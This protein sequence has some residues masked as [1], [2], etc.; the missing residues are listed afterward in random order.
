MSLETDLA[1]LI[2][3]RCPRV[4]ADVAPLDTATP[5]VTWQQVGG[6]AINFTDDLVPTTRNARVQI[7]VWDE[8]RLAANALML[9]LEA[10]LIVSAAFQARAE[11]AGMAANDGDTDLRGFMQ[12]FSIWAPR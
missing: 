9:Q 2:A 8:S 5:Y 4:F 10:D 3:S 7:T 1:A 12:D 11:S 6:S